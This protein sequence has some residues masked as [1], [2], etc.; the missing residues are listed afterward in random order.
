MASDFIFDPFVGNTTLTLFENEDFIQPMTIS[1][2]SLEK[3]IT[4]QAE[5][6]EIN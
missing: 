6:F 2:Q 4:T 1:F 5:V 3:K